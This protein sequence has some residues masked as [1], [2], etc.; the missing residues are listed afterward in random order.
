MTISNRTM[1]TNASIYLQTP[2][3]SVAIFKPKM[4]ILSLLSSISAS[5]RKFASARKMYSRR[6]A[7]LQTGDSRRLGGDSSP[8][9]ENCCYEK[10]DIA[11]AENK[12][13]EK[14]AK[15]DLLFWPYRPMGNRLVEP[16]ARRPIIYISADDGC[17]LF[18]FVGIRSRKMADN[19]QQMHQP[20][21][22]AGAPVP[23]LI[24]RNGKRRLFY[25]QS[26]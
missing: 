23:V 2:I 22:A 5:R 24:T 16:I 17:G 6:P 7:T 21:A 14:S 19:E 4:S 3:P 8:V 20:E 13:S 9:D 10:T 12:K 25:C 26:D 11:R 15:Y 1:A 18:R